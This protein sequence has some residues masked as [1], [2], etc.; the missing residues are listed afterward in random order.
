MRQTLLFLQG[1]QKEYRLAPDLGHYQE[2]QQDISRY[3]NLLSKTR[4]QTLNAPYINIKDDCP[5]Q[6]LP[7]SFEAYRACDLMPGH[8]YKLQFQSSI[9][10]EINENKQYRQFWF[11]HT[12]TFVFKPHATTE[13]EGSQ[14]EWLGKAVTIK[15]RLGSHI[16]VA[17]VLTNGSNPIAACIS[18]TPVFWSRKTTIGRIMSLCS[19]IISTGRE[20]ICLQYSD[21]AIWQS[22]T[23]LC[24][25]A[26]RG[27]AGLFLCKSRLKPREINYAWT[28]HPTGY[29]IRKMFIFVDTCPYSNVALRIVSLW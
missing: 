18:A 21:L 19:D 16:D 5:L 2:C 14:R 8:W 7:A 28:L 12:Q 23:P 1:Y 27:S 22:P 9:R 6:E 3:T 17:T 4:N 11:N 15:L 26:N 29:I 25:N 24:R 20:L 10:A 13:T